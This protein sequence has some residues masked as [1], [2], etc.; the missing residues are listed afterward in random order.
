MSEHWVVAHGYVLSLVNVLLS[1]D[2]TSFPGFVKFDLN[3]FVKPMV[4]HISK[5]Y[6]RRRFF[7]I[8]LY[9]DNS[10]QWNSHD[11]TKV[12]ESVLFKDSWVDFA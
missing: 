1:P 4:E 8:Y 6:Q 10:S 2:H 9:F 5:W 11:I 3:L 7:G 12:V